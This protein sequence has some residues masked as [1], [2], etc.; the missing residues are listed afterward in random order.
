MNS[1]RLCDVVCGWIWLVDTCRSRRWSVAAGPG[2]HITSQSLQ[3]FD[4]DPL[5]NQSVSVPAVPARR[6]DA[7]TSTTTAPNNSQTQSNVQRFDH[8]TS[9]PPRSVSSGRLTSSSSDGV[10]TATERNLASGRGTVSNTLKRALCRHVTKKSTQPA[11]ENPPRPAAANRSPRRV[12][13]VMPV[14][15]STSD[16]MALEYAGGGGGKVT[17]F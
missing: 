11:A 9:V 14:T 8:T 13:D 17:H 4:A 1:E 16:V 10:T 12:D 6:P 15:S 2:G 7:T 5:S 3:I